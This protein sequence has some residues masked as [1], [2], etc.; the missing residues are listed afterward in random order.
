ML[1]STLEACHLWLNLYLFL[2]SGS[3]IVPYPLTLFK[4]EFLQTKNHSP[5]WGDAHSF[6]NYV[7]VIMW[8]T[9][10]MSMLS[11]LVCCHTFKRTKKCASKMWTVGNIHDVCH[12]HPPPAMGHYWALSYCRYLWVMGFSVLDTLSVIVFFFRWLA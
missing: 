9:C 1:F 3:Y 4:V 2:I 6:T 12:P 11:P 8:H 7:A 10:V 5:T